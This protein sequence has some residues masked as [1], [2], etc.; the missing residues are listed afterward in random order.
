MG[1]S[2]S[3]LENMVG[4]DPYAYALRRQQLFNAPVAQAQN[5]Y[6]RM[7]AALGNIVGG[8]IFGLE[9]QNLKRAADINRIYS[10]VM[11][12]TDPTQPDFAD[13]L[14]I[15]TRQLSNAGYGDAAMYASNQARAIKKEA[16]AEAR[17]EEELGIRKEDLEL[18]RKQAAEAKETNLVT[19]NGDPIVK[20]EG[21]FFVQTTDDEGNIK[22]N[23]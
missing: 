5:P 17:A 6:E 15:L 18:R 7:G 1:R 13:R 2:V 22:L 8:S 9:D 14:G 20:K 4:F 23:P 12:G 3:T 11:A 16:A 21:K 19:T 10:D